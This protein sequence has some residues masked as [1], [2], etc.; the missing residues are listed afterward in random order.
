M[1]RITL[2]LS[3]EKVLTDA[4]LGILGQLI[5]NWA[6][7]VPVYSNQKLWLLHVE[8]RRSRTDKFITNHKLTFWERSSCKTWNLR[9]YTLLVQVTSKAFRLIFQILIPPS[10]KDDILEC[11]SEKESFW[12]S[13][14]LED[15]SQISDICSKT[16]W[17]FLLLFLVNKNWLTSDSHLT[18]IKFF[19]Q[20][21]SNCCH[22][23]INQ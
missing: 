13:L 2:I 23:H 10:L 9:S 22:M 7:M 1:H 18:E 19:L 12:C 11:T 16:D 20:L 6:R 17:H 14:T 21:L 8:K 15:G 3:G 5:L 4:S